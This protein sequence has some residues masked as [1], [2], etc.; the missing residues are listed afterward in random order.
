MKFDGYKVLVSFENIDQELKKEVH[1]INIPKAQRKCIFCCSNTAKF[2]KIAHAVS[3]TVGNKSLISHFECDD[4]NEEFGRKLEDN[5][6]KYML[7]YKIITQ[8]FG[9]NNQLIS[10]DSSNN[11]VS[12][13]SFRIQ[14]N[15][16]KP[17]L[18]G[19][20]TK[21]I[22]IETNGTGIIKEV[23]DG[24]EIAI[25][26][27]HYNPLAVFCSFL[28]MAYS[29]MPLKF[30][31]QYVKHI[32]ALKQ[33]VAKDSKYSDEEK[34]KIMKSNPNCGLLCF[35]PGINPL[36]GI[37]VV[38]WQKENLE[39]K[40]YPKM[41]FTLEMKNFSFT[42]PV[43]ADEEQGNF[44]MPKFSSDKELQYRS[45]DFSKEEMEFKCIMSAKKIQNIEDLASLEEE[46][47]KRK[48]LK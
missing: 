8:I 16:N 42:I 38:L 23:D 48:L 13:G 22:I 4:C 28:K 41:L 7:P 37:N 19:V 2:T 45:L 20:E 36:G 27:Q 40:L 15:K 26:R 6:G 46:L 1:D 31:E 35:F 34:E 9:K 29:I 10:K 33:I 25:P 24:F 14:V 39:E 43:L 17:V 12:Y 11:D 47:R 44:K 21:G 5:L 3:E 18:E 32:A 30:Y